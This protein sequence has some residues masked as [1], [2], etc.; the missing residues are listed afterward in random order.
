MESWRG[1]ASGI[2][3]AHELPGT[4]EAPPGYRSRRADALLVLD[5][6]REPRLI[7][8]PVVVDALLIFE[9]F[10]TFIRERLD[11]DTI[12]LEL[13]KVTSLFATHVIASCPELIHR[14][15]SVSR[16]APTP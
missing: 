5:R 13:Q 14:K 7:K 16:R 4:P 9:T 6:A 1:P 15:A 10:I 2:L 11:G 3:S 8:Q 12:Y